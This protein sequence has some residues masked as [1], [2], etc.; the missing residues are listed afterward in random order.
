MKL[1]IGIPTQDTMPGECVAA[2][3]AVCVEA[4]ELV[5]KTNLSILSPSN[6]S[7]H[8]RSRFIVAEEALR[9]GCDRLF[10]MDDDTITPRNG[11]KHLMDTMTE[12]KCQAVTGFYLRRGY[13]YTSV[14]TQEQDGQYYN[15]DADGGI[16]PIH[17]S[18]LGSCLINLTWCRDNLPKPW[19][20]MDQNDDYTIISDDASFFRRL[21]AAGG[22]LLGDAF[23]H[24]IH[25]G[26]REMISRDTAAGLRSASQALML[27]QEKSTATPV[28]IPQEESKNANARNESQVRQAGFHVAADSPPT[29]G[30]AKAVECD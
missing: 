14:W 15:V 21:R 16:H 10:F 26:R 30:E 3:G 24:C 18:G 5:G 8:D 25:V 2:F 11:L 29:G 13:P 19:F 27:A 1:A 12:R 28:I 6:Y 9:L 23:V 17:Y 7:P 22:V 20:K 4:F